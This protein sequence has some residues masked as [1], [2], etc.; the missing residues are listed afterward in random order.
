MA[1]TKNDADLEK[2][3][4]HQKEEEEIEA[5]A[6]EKAADA[7]HKIADKLT[8]EDIEKARKK[9][10]RNPDGEDEEEEEPEEEAGEGDEEK[11]F[12]DEAK[13]ESSEIR[14]AVEVTDFLNDLVKAIG[15]SMD[16]LRK[17]VTD[18]NKAVMSTL[19]TMAKS[20]ATV[21]E[22]VQDLA[23]RV[24]DLEKTP[25]GGKKSITASA[26][27]E[28]SFSDAG[29]ELSGDEI[30]DQLTEWAMKGEHGITSIDVSQYETTR[31]LTKAAQEAL[32]TLKK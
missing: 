25:V 6:L 26:G 16:S 23:D 1:Q 32:N 4:E 12:Y 20:M 30:L 21:A 13:D 10:G 19:A 11:S 18:S 3:Q 8:D 22:E 14:K 2:T 5:S 9:G 17:S 29:T 27:I 7:L 28:R 24:E 31:T 15:K